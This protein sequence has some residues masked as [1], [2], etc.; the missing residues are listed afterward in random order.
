[1]ADTR[2][3][4]LPC[5]AR[6]EPKKNGVEV[7]YGDT[8]IQ[9]GDLWQCPS[10]GHEMIQGLSSEVIYVSDDLTGRRERAIVNA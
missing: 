9:P 10:C 5:P 4:C 3:I 6:Y 2:P 1:M 8:G 7:A